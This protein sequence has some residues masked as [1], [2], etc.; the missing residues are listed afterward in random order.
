MA[1]KIKTIWSS[2]KRYIHTYIWSTYNRW[3][4]INSYGLDWLTHWNHEVEIQ[5][6]AE[7]T[8][9]KRSIYYRI[10]LRTGTVDLFHFLLNNNVSSIKLNTEINLGFRYIVVY[11]KVSRKWTKLSRSKTSP[12][13][14]WYSWQLCG[15]YW[16]NTTK[17]H[18]VVK[19][20]E[21][22]RV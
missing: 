14:K 9:E 19:E 7:T 15:K 4:I 17:E 21:E 10:Q 2:G 12:A 16:K 8:L 22:S 5:L 3:Q 1:V 18:R 11:D 20:W 13:L 6:T